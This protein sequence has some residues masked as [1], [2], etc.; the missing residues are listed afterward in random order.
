[1][2]LVLV[3]NYSRC[4]LGDTAGFARNFEDWRGAL[5]AS[6]EDAAALS[7][8]AARL[9]DEY[10]G[11]YDWAYEFSGER[12][13]EV[14]IGYLVFRPRNAALPVLEGEWSPEALSF[15]AETCDYVGFVRCEASPKADGR[16]EAR[17]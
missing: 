10:I 16:A 2:R 14:S 3:D 12:A 15:L 6:A 5:A 17:I 8:L 13:C 11:E 4:I 7:L 1:M 9:L